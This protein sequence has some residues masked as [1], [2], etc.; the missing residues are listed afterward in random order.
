MR[1]PTEPRKNQPT[2]SE[3]IDD[4]WVGS[5]SVHRARQADHILHAAVDIIAADG[6]AG[7][8]MSGLAQ[9][10]GISRQTLYKYYAD[11][12]A[13]L[14]GLASMGAAGVREL[15]D[16]VA[17]EPD[18]ASGLRVLVG[19]ILAASAVHPS[20]VALLAVLPAGMREA[21]RH[22]EEQAEDVVIE[23]LRRG[24][25]DGSFRGD[26]DPE[27][28]GRIVYRAVHASHDLAHRPGTDVSALADHIS[29]ALLRMLGGP[30]PVAPSDT[31]SA[32]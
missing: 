10:A 27:L 28:D 9:H 4:V 17:A 30:G 32:P 21:M 11:V 18:A 1:Q 23:L 6:I 24:R 14:A 2:D 13:V 29:D 31:P 26:L 20:P 12:D 16:R 15:A 19:A 25:D 5:L 3:P 22:H 7:L 8:S